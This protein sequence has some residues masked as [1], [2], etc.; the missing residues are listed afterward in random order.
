MAS[1]CTVISGFS[2]EILCEFDESDSSDGHYLVAKG[3]FDS[4]QYVGDEF[5]FYISEIKNPFSTQPSQSFGLE[6]FDKYGGLQYYFDQEF[7]LEVTASQFS[8]AFI[9]SQSQMNGVSSLFEVTL[10]LGVDTPA[11]AYL[12]IGLPDELDF[13]SDQPFTCSGEMNV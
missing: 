4:E 5:S 7:T 12:A 6:I 10:T 9:E 2:D 1:T 8:F 13:D 3:G 11:G